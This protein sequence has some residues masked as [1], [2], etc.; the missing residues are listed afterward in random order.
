[1]NTP[2]PLHAESNRAPFVIEP[3]ETPVTFLS[4]IENLLKKPGR[5]LHEC[6]QSGPSVP[7]RL[8]LTALGCLAIFGLL[9]GTFSGGVQLWAAP[10]KVSL[11]MG[12]ALLIC[13]PSLYVFSA[14]GG[15]DARLGQITVLLLLMAGLTGLLLVGFAPVAWVFSQSTDSIGFMGFLTLTFWLISLGFGAKLLFKAA[16]GLQA[17]SRGYLSLWWGIFL[18]VTLQMSTSLRPII[19]TADTL[20]PTEKRFFIEHWMDTMSLTTDAR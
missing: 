13:L 3:M 8:G 9:L 20:L 16:D 19:G 11:G 10:L 6:T 15:I 1:M 14:L 5:L 18:V 17:G 12:T 2:P 7:W 4:V